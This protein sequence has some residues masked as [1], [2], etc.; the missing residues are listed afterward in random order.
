M[1]T[2]RLFSPKHHDDASDGLLFAVLDGGALADSVA[3]PHV[4]HVPDEK[5]RP[6]RR[7]K[8]DRPDVLFVPDHADAPDDELFVHPVDDV[9]PNVEVV[10]G[11]G[12]VDILDRQAVLQ[13]FT[14]A[15]DHLVL[16]DVAAER[17]DFVDSANGLEE[18]RDQPVLES[19]EVHE[20]PDAG[21]LSVRLGPFQGVLV[22]LAHGRGNRAHLHADP[23][24]NPFTNLG[25]SLEN[26]LPGEINVRSILEDQGDDRDAEFGDRA[27]QVEAR[28]APHGHLDGIGHESFDLQRGKSG[29]QADDLDLDVR[30]VRKSVDGDGQERVDPE[31]DQEHNQENDKCPLPKAEGDKPLN[32]VHARPSRR[33]S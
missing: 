16:F 30:H 17:V 2:S 32:R 3:Y 10:G 7:R 13:E 19:A 9:A 24:R 31:P 5:R 15:E 29:G 4:G 8:G 18:R 1:T 26:E 14:R 6:P 33:F 11:D 28:E 21:F 12:V 22:D 25:Q 20:V 27:H 23:A